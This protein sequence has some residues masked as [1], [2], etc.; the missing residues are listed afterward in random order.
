M[1]DTLS[2]I[3]LALFLPLFPMS[4]V[5]NFVFDR[6]D[7]YFARLVLLAG[8]PLFGIYLASTLAP[9]LPAGLAWWAVATS[10]LYAL[11]VLSLREVNQWTAFIAVSFWSLLWIAI[12]SE[13]PDDLLYTFAIG[14]NLPLLMLLILSHRLSKRFGAAYTGIYGGLGRTIPRFSGVFVIAILGIIATPLFPSFFVMLDLIIATA[15]NQFLISLSL[16]LIWLVWSWAGARLIQGLIVGAKNEYRIR[17]LST[18]ATSLYGLTLFI[19]LAVGVY[20]AGVIL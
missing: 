7:N 3:V 12:Q 10:A 2:I 1:N 8:W 11:R 9:D 18:L 14:I 19:M 5:F 16:L 13:T 6:V 17:D 15:K 4:M 20:I